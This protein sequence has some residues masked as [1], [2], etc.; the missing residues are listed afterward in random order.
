MSHFQAL[1]GQPPLAIPPY[2]K[3]PTSIQALDETLSE[4]DALL[5]S[6]KE[7]LRQAQRRMIQKT[8]GHKHEAQFAVGD[9]VLVKLQP[10]CQNTVASRS[11]QKLAKRYYGHFPASSPEDST[12]EE[13]ETFY[14][15]YP[16]FHLEDKLMK[17][18]SSQV[19]VKV[20]H[21]EGLPAQE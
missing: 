9:Q 16:D 11:C 10:Y 17:E 1:F 19:E 7:N 6:L 4:R 8:N 13:F 5:R 21:E 18:A 3:G 15:L 14:K 2:S 12:W 20:A